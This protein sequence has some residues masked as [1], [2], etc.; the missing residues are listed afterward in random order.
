MYIYYENELTPPRILDSYK[1]SSVFQE[2]ENN[3]I[4]DSKRIPMRVQI[5]NGGAL[6]TSLSSD[7]KMSDSDRSEDFNTNDMDRNSVLAAYNAMPIQLNLSGSRLKSRNSVDSP[8]LES[9]D[10]NEDRKTTDNYRT[11]RASITSENYSF[12]NNKYSEK[13]HHFPNSTDLG[14]LG[15]LESV[16][17][18]ID[19]KLSTEKLET[20]EEP[21]K[22]HSR[23]RSFLTNIG[24]SGS[25]SRTRDSK[26][27]TDQNINQK[28]GNDRRRNGILFRRTDSKN[29]VCVDVTD[30]INLDSNYNSN[31]VDSVKMTSEING[32]K[33]LLNMSII[34]IYCVFFSI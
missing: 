25:S 1:N 30:S 10:Y 28:N 11:K 2:G 4:K 29:D 31:I 22:V 3:S 8:D 20:V 32:N 12:E 15:Q 23:L 17:N 16:S 13:S 7:S 14:G 19:E 9:L 33:H 34:Y 18:S 5:A 24:M 21:K 26:K 6:D 27:N